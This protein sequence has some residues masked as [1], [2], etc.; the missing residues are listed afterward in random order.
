MTTVQ[1]ERRRVTVDRTAGRLPSQEAERAIVA[2]IAV[3]V[4]LFLL[5]M[6]GLV[7]TL[8]TSAGSS[9]PQGPKVNIAPSDGMPRHLVIGHHYQ[10]TAQV[11]L[12]PHWYDGTNAA[13]SPRTSVRVLVIDPHDGPEPR[14]DNAV[15]FI[16]AEGAVLRVP[17]ELTPSRPGEITVIIAVALD[18]RTS[19]RVNDQAQLRIV[20][21]LG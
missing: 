17:I 21:D 19:P 1:G 10:G 11:T 8:P 18:G 3:L 14:I 5:T 20:H 4:G 9:E 7:P 6:V 16:P 12:P 2:V 15:G 13:Q